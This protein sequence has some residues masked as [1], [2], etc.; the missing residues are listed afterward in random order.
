MTS[1]ATSRR[2]L[3]VRPVS[4]GLLFVATTYLGVLSGVPAGLGVLVA[5]LGVVAA[6]LLRTRPSGKGVVY[7]PVPVLVVLALEAGFA[8]VGFGTE[9]VAGLAGL[10][11][12]VWLADDP[13]RPAGGPL[14]A[15]PSIAIPSLALSIAWS[16]ALFLPAGTFPLG[17]AGVL[18][19]IT[20][21]AVAYLVGRPSLFDRE[22]A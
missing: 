16:S 5:P 19:A 1:T 21:A 7:A 14:R 6:A 22:E 20:L 10:A 11:F 8:P 2:G 18:L 15:F 3:P 4:L 13:T 12:L 9:L 17:V